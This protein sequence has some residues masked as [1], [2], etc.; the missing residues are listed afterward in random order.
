MTSRTK[1]DRPG[2]EHTLSRNI[3]RGLLLGGIEP[4]SDPLQWLDGP[5]DFNVRP[6]KAVD[7]AQIYRA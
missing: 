1:R 6:T 2:L 7:D 4:E 5:D 3:P